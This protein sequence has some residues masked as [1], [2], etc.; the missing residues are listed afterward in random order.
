MAKLLK[1]T[2]KQFLYGLLAILVVLLIGT[3]YHQHTHFNPKV[4]INEVPVGGLTAKQAFQKVRH[5]QKAIKVY[6]NNDLVYQRAASSTGFTNGDEAKFQAA[7]KKQ[8]TFFP[9]KKG[10]NIIVTPTKLDRSPLT[11]IDQAVSDKISSLNANRKPAKD[12]YAKYSHGTV[13]VIPAVYGKQ[14]SQ[15]GLKRQ[16]R[17]ELA[18]GTIKLKPAYI[19]PLTSRSATVQ[20]EKRQLDRLR[21][22]AVTYQ[23]QK[24]HYQFKTSDVIASAT[25]QDGHNTS[26][27]APFHEKSG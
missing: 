18:N 14:F 6:V 23:V 10:Q 3:L 15:Q 9:S 24:Q 22:K 5:R 17:R 16:V 2:P 12:A 1:I 26:I 11:A 19:K 27:P 13:K 4:T 25:Y 21:G 7:L 20:N 8:H